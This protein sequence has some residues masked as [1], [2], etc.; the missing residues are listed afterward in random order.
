MQKDSY[1]ARITEKLNQIFEM[2]ETAPDIKE[3]LTSFNNEISI[4]FPV[5]R[6]N[7]RIHIVRG[8]RTQ[9]NNILGP[10]KGGLFFHPSID[11][12]T[13]RAMALMRTLKAALADIPMGGSMGAIKINPVRFSKTEIERVVRRY[14]FTLGL[15]IGPEYD[16]IEPSINSNSQ[17]MAWVYDTYISC[18]P[19]HLRNAVRHICT[20]K[21]IPLGGT[22]YSDRA[23]P[24]ALFHFISCWC[25]DQNIDLKQVNFMVQGFGNTGY[26]IS[27]LLQ[28]KGARLIAIEDKRGAIYADNGIDLAGLARHVEKEGRVSNYGQSRN[29]D[30][31][32]FLAVD[33]DIAI[34]S[35][36]ENQIDAERAGSLN[37]K[38]LIEGVDNCID[39]ESESILK[40]RGV[41]YIPALIAHN[42]R[43]IVSYYEWLQNKRS[44]MW[45]EEEV[46]SK[47]KRKICSIYE[48]V[49]KRKTEL[50]LDWNQ[51]GLMTAVS[52]LEK[53][54]KE[55]K[56]FP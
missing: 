20:G 8:Y 11:A 52:R 12:E 36:A 54:Y 28:E 35:G 22:V 29:I 39:P 17:I 5:K 56:I 9:H 15:N 37:S 42:G 40:H 49:K 10:Y 30:H 34:F 19:P 50:D 48:R 41:E 13:V 45:A 23:E 24:L 53:V 6:D 46:D 1:Y 44:E 21:P 27:G 3:L 25:Q 51:A 38:L 18:C 4:H 2:A 33:C 43:E 31:E 47:L 7:Q 26:W 16:V 55:R 32:E 14:I